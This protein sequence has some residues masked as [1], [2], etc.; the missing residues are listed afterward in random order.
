[1]K[2][3]HMTLCSALLLFFANSS[4]LAA[5]TVDIE[6]G[7]SL[8][9]NLEVIEIDR[10]CTEVTV[11]LV[12]TGRMP[13]AAMGHNWVLSATA[14]YQSVAMDGMSAGIE[15]HYVPV[16]DDRVIATTEVIG[17]GGSTSVTFSIADLDP[18]GAYT[19]FCSFP[20]HWGVMKGE[21]RII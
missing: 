12:H 10:A 4:V 9:F 6:A 20:G 1:M 8:A 14:D 11:N 19:F 18:S 13:A 15:N 21:F 7:D 17:G 3:S 5:C 16:D 2:R